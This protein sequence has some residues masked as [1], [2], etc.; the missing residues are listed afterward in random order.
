MWVSCKCWWS[1]WAFGLL[2]VLLFSWLSHFLGRCDDVCKNSDTPVPLSESWDAAEEVQG[3]CF[4]CFA[5]TKNWCAQKWWEL[6]SV[7]SWGGG[8]ESMFFLCLLPLDMVCYSLFLSSD[9]CNSWLD[10]APEVQPSSEMHSTWVIKLC[11][12][13]K[14]KIFGPTPSCS[15][16]YFH[17]L[18][19][20]TIA[21]CL[22]CVLLMYRVSLLRPRWKP[23]FMNMENWMPKTT[24][25]EQKY[26]RLRIRR[27]REELKRKVGLSSLKILVWASPSLRSY[28]DME[29]GVHAFHFLLCCALARMCLPL[30]KCILSVGFDTVLL[31]MIHTEM[32]KQ[33][34]RQC[35]CELCVQLLLDKTFWI[36]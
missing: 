31:F 5:F 15:S 36:L 26:W 4:M 11:H 12:M 22:M 24:F 9:S 13:K 23:G 34:D 3:K 8:V 27:K 19:G 14:G 25:Q 7:S 32:G 35:S 30:S 2:R 6:V 16:R 33:R 18:V 20:I 28:M 1:L 21:V 29:P 17:G 10:H